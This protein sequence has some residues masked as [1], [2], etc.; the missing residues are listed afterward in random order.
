MLIYGK[1]I[2]AL[3]PISWGWELRSRESPA[4]ETNGVLVDGRSQDMAEF[5]DESS[6]RGLGP[7]APPPTRPD[8]AA[9]TNGPCQAGDNRSIAVANFP[10]ASTGAK[11]ASMLSSLA[12]PRTS[13][14]SLRGLPRLTLSEPKRRIAASATSGIRLRIRYARA[15][16]SEGR[17]RPQKNLASG[18]IA[19]KKSFVLSKTKFFR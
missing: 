14:E 11:P 8:R 15:F 2:L 10:F 18:R 1:S 9:A 16:H 19:R 17:R 12:S 3:P 7:A 4:P 13:P 5:G 6:V